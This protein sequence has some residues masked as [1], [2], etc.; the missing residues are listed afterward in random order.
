MDSSLHGCL[1]MVMNAE[2]ESVT[3]KDKRLQYELFFYWRT[4]IG[5]GL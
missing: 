4:G 5:F 3:V 2:P 1:L